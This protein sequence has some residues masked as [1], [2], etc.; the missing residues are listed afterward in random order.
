L[1]P[2]P[3]RSIPSF[4][5]ASRS[6]NHTAKA[7][8]SVNSRVVIS[9]ISRFCNASNVLWEATQSRNLPAATSCLIPRQLSHPHSHARSPTTHPCH[10]KQRGREHLKHKS[11]TLG[12]LVTT[13]MRSASRSELKLMGG[14]PYPNS[15]CLQRFN[16]NCALVLQLVHSS[17]NTTF[18]VVLAFLWKTG[19]V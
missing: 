1:F 18:L 7:S 3:S 16:A 8:R 17:L 5:L 11:G 4:D 14:M 10:E 9:E 6:G 15:K 2:I 13:V 19:L 12:L